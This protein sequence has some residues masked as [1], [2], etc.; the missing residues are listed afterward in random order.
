MEN[1]GQTSNHDWTGLYREFGARLLLFARQLAPALNEA[2]DIVQ[3]AFVRYWRS[4][5]AQPG[6][7]STLLFRFVKQIAVD[8]WRRNQRRQFWE[9]K[10]QA[11]PGE[12]VA[13]FVCPCE[14]SEQ[15]AAIESALQTL[16]A[17]QRETLVLKIWGGL[18]FEQI[19]EVLNIPAN[20]AA[21]RYRY[22]LDNLKR[23]LAVSML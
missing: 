20:T 7:P 8:H 21:S 1:D 3:E 15:S 9:A 13:C 23:T 2:E 12:P 16:P 17:S 10:A 11:E 14:A 18:T 4:R 6:L 19:A 5:E 22:A